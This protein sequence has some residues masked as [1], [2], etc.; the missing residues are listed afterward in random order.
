MAWAHSPQGAT[1]SRRGLPGTGDGALGTQSGLLPE[2]PALVMWAVAASSGL[3]H[4]VGG[5]GPS[6]S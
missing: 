3:R 5:T 2:R 4:R 1:G 6:S